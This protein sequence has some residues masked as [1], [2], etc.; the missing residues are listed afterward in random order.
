MPFLKSLP[1][2]AGPPSIFAAYPD[3]YRPWSEM[4]QTL[5]NGTSPLSPAERE[6][7]LAFAAGTAG[8]TY[9]YSAH[10][11]VAYAWGIEEGT[12]ERLV[13]DIQSVAIDGRLK[14]L[15]SFVRKLI[16]TP[17]ELTQADADAVFSAG[18]DEKALH[19]AIAIA[20]RASFMQRLV[21]GYGFTPLSK[22]TARE[23]A[24]KRVK[25]G[26][27]ELYGAFAKQG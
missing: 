9:V 24:K 23:R 25:L 20:A 14:S 1:E 7:I 15:L 8:C 19:D 17:K 18:C 4:S 2:H 21:E 3:L 12:V 11:E 16:L 13:K 26:Y 5:M 22:E 10:A 6:L 27:V